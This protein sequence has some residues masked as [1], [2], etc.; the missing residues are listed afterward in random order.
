MVSCLAESAPYCLFVFH[1]KDTAVP[2]SGARWGPACK[3]VSL[4]KM[5]EN[6]TGARLALFTTVRLF[7]LSNFFHQRLRALSRGQKS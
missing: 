3:Y 2:L 7:L 4:V 1:S 6:T 5:A